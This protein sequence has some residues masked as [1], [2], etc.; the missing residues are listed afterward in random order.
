MPFAFIANHV[1]LNAHPMQTAASCEAQ[2]RDQRVPVKYAIDQECRDQNKEDL[3]EDDACDS[4]CFHR[5]IPHG[6]K[7]PCIVAS[8]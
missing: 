4:I 2:Q 7:T 3:R 5:P 8:D 1:I 6:Q